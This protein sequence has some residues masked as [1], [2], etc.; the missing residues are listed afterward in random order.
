M[1]K[2]TWDVE[3]IKERCLILG[4]EF[5][6]SDYKHN[7]KG[8]FKCSCGNKFERLFLNVNKG[9]IYCA[10][11]RKEKDIAEKKEFLKNKF[12][13]FKKYVEEESSS[14]CV[15]LSFHDEYLSNKSKIKIRCAC[16]EIFNPTANNFTRGHQQCDSCGSIEAGKK[17]RISQDE[18]FKFIESYGYKPL[19]YKFTNEHRIIVKCNIEHHNPYDVSYSNFYSGHRCPNCNQS[20]G[21]KKVEDFLIENKIYFEQ[22]FTFDDL[23]GGNNQGLRFDFYIKTDKE[24][25]LVEY[26]G[27]QHYEPKFGEEEFIRTKKNDKRKNDYCS[28]NNIKLLRIPYTEFDNIEKIL[29]KNI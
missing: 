9:Q 17:K 3:K 16:G 24:E 23:I 5:L 29:L 13:E 14:N 10:E 6:D 18:I 27:I 7:V 21:E 26:D 28:K 20:K 19:E 22:Q 2:P 15:V 8:N 25:F 4:I 1:K 11:C 12:Y